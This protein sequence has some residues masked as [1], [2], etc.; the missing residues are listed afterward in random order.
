MPKHHIN[1]IQLCAD[2]VFKDTKNVRAM[3]NTAWCAVGLAGHNIYVKKRVFL[4][5]M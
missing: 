4:L 5:R 2:I 3:D 1:I